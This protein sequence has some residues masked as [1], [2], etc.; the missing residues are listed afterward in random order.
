MTSNFLCL[1]ELEIL[2]EALDQPV[3]LCEFR[4]QARPTLFDKV[5]PETYRSVFRVSEALRVASAVARKRGVEEPWKA[6]QQTSS[7]KNSE[8]P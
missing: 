8:E 4:R 7:D 2:A 1:Q 3:C 6:F 5:S